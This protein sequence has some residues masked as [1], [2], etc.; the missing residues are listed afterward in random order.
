M[1]ETSWLRVELTVPPQRFVVDFTNAGGI[2][3]GHAVRA[4]KIKELRGRRRMCSRSKCDVNLVFANEIEG[5]LN[6]ICASNLVIDVLN[7]GFVEREQ[8]Q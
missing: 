5:A 7:A 2:L 8:S 4:G 1:A 6:I 3:V